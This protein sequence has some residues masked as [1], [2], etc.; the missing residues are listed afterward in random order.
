[1]KKWFVLAIALL[2]ATVSLAEGKAAT[3]KD[4]AS[5]K[6]RKVEATAQ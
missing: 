3:K 6:E 2:V 4:Q 1:M 5:R